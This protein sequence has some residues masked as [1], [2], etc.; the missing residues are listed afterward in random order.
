MNR[1]QENRKS[2]FKNSGSYAF[3]RVLKIKDTCYIPLSFLIKQ[4]V[5]KTHA[6]IY[7]QQENR[8]STSKGIWDMSGKYLQK[9]PQRIFHLKWQQKRS[10]EVTHKNWI[11]CRNKLENSSNLEKQKYIYP[12][13]LSLNA[14]VKHS[15]MGWAL[16]HL[17]DCQPLDKIQYC[18]I[19]I[20]L[21]VI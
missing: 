12:W 9:N 14:G 3:K 18:L 4:T 8:N 21:A 13:P 20:S 5:L 1:K 15:Q 17:R 2:F 10:I 16:G 19:H 6:A 7:T 11:H